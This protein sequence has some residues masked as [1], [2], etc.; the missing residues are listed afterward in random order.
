MSET[1]VAQ[2]GS[3]SGSQQQGEGAQLLRDVQSTAQAFEQ[4]DWLNGALGVVKV[5]MGALDVAGDPLGAI[6]SAGVGWVLGAVSFLREPFDVLK[7]DS[8]AV[9]SSAQS[10]GG[11]SSS[12]GSTAEQYR[13]AAGSETR[14]WTGQA[15]EG[16]RAASANQ[17]DGLAALGQASQAISGAMQQ[18][19][20]AV[21]QARQT[22]MELISEAVQK[23]VQI[24]LEA[25][26][27][28]WL[29]FGASIAMGIAQSVQKAVQTAQKMAQE[30]QQ[31][32][33]TLQKIIQVVQKVVQIA[34][35]VKELVE[36]IGGKASAEQ[37]H[38]MSTQQ[39]SSTGAMA[40]NTNPTGGGVL[41]APREEIAPGYQYSTPAMAGANGTGGPTTSASM[42]P[43]GGPVSATPTA[44]GG[45]VHQASAGTTTGAQV[46]ATPVANGGGV[47]QA[48]AGGQV[49]GGP[50]SATPVANGGGVQ[51][52]TPQG[53]VS[54]P[55]T[56]PPTT[57]TGG[58]QTAQ[59]Q[60]PVVPPAQAP[61]T[62]AP[63]RPQGPVS[64]NGWPVNPPRGARTIP[65]TNTR[66]NVADGPAGDVLM[67]VLGQVHTRVENIDMLSDAG[68]HDD[69]G[70]AERNVRG[71]GDISNHA[72]ATAVDINATRH[73]LGA[74]D[75]F[76]PAQAQEIR[77]I[78][79]EVDNVVRWGG[80][81]TRRADEM[82]F[83][84]VGTPEEV[85][86]VAER[87]RAAQGVQQ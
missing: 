22:V 80:D 9:S 60:P 52:T 56:A 46:S 54:A 78:L 40:T 35:Q 34:Q 61:A 55:V 12:L 28:S 19:G 32:I 50:V 73:V 87:L 31:L 13:A 3:G 45:G 53:A 48:S 85:S 64:Q 63:A 76:T 41:A 36:M 14:S 71:S 43:T 30:I 86:R 23:I 70:Y 27:K 2:T 67:H 16:Y 33:Q 21:A 65:G 68:E 20:Q 8:G 75:T 24:C 66:V 18:G 15:A 7:G 4:G 10:W 79:G 11:L 59:A 57:G 37:P 84:I 81:Y 51:T 39:V 42:T 5:A 74:R 44:T 83:E 49:T 72:S 6:G 38:T 69:W 1:L 58:V 47:H 26:S 77:T 17:A 62:A 25:L 29:S 82:H